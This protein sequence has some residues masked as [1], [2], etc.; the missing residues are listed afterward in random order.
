MVTMFHSNGSFSSAPGEVIPAYADF[1]TFGIWRWTTLYKAW[2]LYYYSTNIRIFKGWQFFCLAEKIKKCWL[3]LLIFFF[4][5]FPLDNCNSLLARLP[6]GTLHQHTFI[7]NAAAQVS[8]G[9]VFLS[10][11]P[12]LLKSPHWLPELSWCYDFTDNQAT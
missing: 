9:L 12:L 11:L 5:L 6:E 4:L 1:G 8:W 10:M 3:I 2:L 7:S